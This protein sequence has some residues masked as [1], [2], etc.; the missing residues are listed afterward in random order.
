MCGKSHVRTFFG[1][2][3]N[4]KHVRI[5]NEKSNNSNSGGVTKNRKAQTNKQANKQTS[6][7]KHSQEQSVSFTFNQRHSGLFSIYAYA[8]CEQSACTCH[9]ALG[10]RNVKL[11]RSRQEYFHQ[12]DGVVAHGHALQDA[13]DTNF[14]EVEVNR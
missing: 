13:H 4:T 8:P 9:H 10:T 7:K 14:L 11:R 5:R 12:S 1:V 6:K 2:S 3:V